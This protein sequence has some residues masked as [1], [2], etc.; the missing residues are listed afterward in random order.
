MRNN[1]RLTSIAWILAI[2][3]FLGACGLFNSPSETTDIEDSNTTEN[4]QSIEESTTEDITSSMEPSS[5]NESTDTSS[6]SETDESTDTEEPSTTDGSTSTDAPSTTDETTESSVS[7]DDLFYVRTSF[8]DSSSQTG[9]FASYENAVKQ[10]DSTGQAVFNAKGELLYQATVSPTPTTPDASPTSTPTS[11]GDYS[12]ISNA[13][14]GWYYTA[15]TPAASDSPATIDSRRQNLLNKYGALWDLKSDRKVVYITMDEG[16]EYENNTSRILDIAKAKKAK[17]SFF[18][19]GHFITSQPDLVRRMLDEGH[20]VANHTDKHLVQ[21]DA[22]DVSTD[23][24]VQDIKKVND[25]FRALTGQN[26]APY[27]RPPT[28]AWSERSLAVSKDLGYT[29]VFWSFAYRDWE[30][31]NQPNP[32]SAY[33]MVMDK[34]YPGS[35]LLLH[36][37]STTN[38]EILGRVI[39]GIRSRG[40]TIELLP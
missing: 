10:A 24:L 35:I 3:L 1:K 19:T 15:G 22:L 6:S 40:Y 36:A 12:S 11:I 7:R 14:E 2:N 8:E 32:D 9:A 16:Y 4:S 17:I 33:K 27:M 25:Q 26:L 28:G 5:T 37:V 38:V 20:Q 29:P 30:V 13:S 31:D 39:D 34:L 18:V 21:P 23:T